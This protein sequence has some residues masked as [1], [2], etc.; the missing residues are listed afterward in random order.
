VKGDIVTPR[1]LADHMGITKAKVYYWFR[2]MG[3]DLPVKWV[4]AGKQYRAYVEEEDL[5]ECIHLMT[6]EMENGSGRHENG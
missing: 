2:V 3:S 4:K 1:A 5:E 6:K